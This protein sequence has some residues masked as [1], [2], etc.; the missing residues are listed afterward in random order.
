MNARTPLRTTTLPAP[1]LRS[2]PTARHRRVKRGI[3]AGY[4]HGLSPRHRGALEHVGAGGA[5]V[6]AVR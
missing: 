3:V 2:L 5:P 4:L 1:T 6:T